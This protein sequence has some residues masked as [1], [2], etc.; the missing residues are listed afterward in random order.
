M[1]GDSIVYLLVKDGLGPLGHITIQRLVI[2]DIIQSA[3]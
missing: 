1:I 3:Y 2:G